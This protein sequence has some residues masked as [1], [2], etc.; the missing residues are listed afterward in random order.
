MTPHFRKSRKSGPL[1]CSLVLKSTAL[2]TAELMRGSGLYKT[3]RR[4]AVLRDLLAGL[5]ISS[6]PLIYNSSK[7][8]LGVSLDE[9]TTNKYSSSIIRV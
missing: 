8:R 6:L 4:F 9:A 7:T 5:A 2:R 3:L 1:A